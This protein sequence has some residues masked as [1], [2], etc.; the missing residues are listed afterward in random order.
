MMNIL[1][2][3][4]VLGSCVAALSLGSGNQLMAQGRPDPAQMKQMRMDDLRG[5]M[6]IKDDAEWTAI[7]PKV[8]KVMDAQRDL[9]GMRMGGMF[10]GG[11]RRRSGQD[12]NGGDAQRQQ[13]R[14][15]FFGDPSPAVEALQ[16]A[17]DDK[18]PTAE[19]KTKLAAVRAEAKEKEAKLEQAEE[20]LRSV[21]SSRQEAVAVVNGLLK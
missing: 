18:A 5:K 17:L 7:E 15:S 3:S 10:G 19:I 14:S 13:R 12:T 9:L 16:K 21:L 6:E 2:K 4:L 8:S 1:K 20:D 11:R